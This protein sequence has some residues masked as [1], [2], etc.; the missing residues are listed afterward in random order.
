MVDTE[1]VMEVVAVDT[2]AVMVEENKP[3][4]DNSHKD[5]TKAELVAAEAVGEPEEINHSNNG[6]DNRNPVA[7]DSL[8]PNNGPTHKEADATNSESHLCM[9]QSTIWILII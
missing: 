2:A 6:E 9:Y 5:G 8:A 3:G 7:G 1:A 4:K